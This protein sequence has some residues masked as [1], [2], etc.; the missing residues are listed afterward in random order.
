[1][2]YKICARD[3]KSGE[4]VEKVGEPFYDN[5]AQAREAGRLFMLEKQEETGTGW[6]WHLEEIED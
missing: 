6:M 1:M 4:T 5:F 2:K 3:L